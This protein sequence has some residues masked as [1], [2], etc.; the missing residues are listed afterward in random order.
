MIP[1][2][3]ALDP[4]HPSSGLGDVGTVPAVRVRLGHAKNAIVVAGLLDTGAELSMLSE[5]IAEQLQAVA[6]LQSFG[7]VSLATGL[8]NLT[9]KLY[10]LDIH[11]LG[12]GPD[13]TMQFESV[14]VA[15]GPLSYPP[16]LLG[17]RGL[18]ERMRLDL[19]FPNRQVTISLPKT[20]STKYPALGEMCPSLPSILAAL[21]AGRVSQ[22]VMMLAWDIE[23]LA[24]RV[25]AVP[26]HENEA[27]AR[28]R[29]TLREKLVTLTGIDPD[30]DFLAAVQVFVQARNWAA[31]GAV[32][33]WEGDIGA[34]LASAENIVSRMSGLTPNAS[35][36]D[37]D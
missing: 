5:S 30:P 16:L 31:H 6:G 32:P 7:A 14:P 28:E 29:R 19:D 22:A 25:A 27:G 17:R 37:D 35:G 2:V 12:H 21:A 8:S 13:S 23:R 11:I 4:S 9:V 33:A 20:I 34:I 15:V 26:S 24:D 1:M 3:P 10:H 18:L 36:A